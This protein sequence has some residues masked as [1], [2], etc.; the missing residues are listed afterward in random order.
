MR[1][2]AMRPRSPVLSPFV[3]SLHYHEADLP[4]EL[5]RVALE[6]VLPGA[7]TH[8]MI[9]LYENEFRTYHGADSTTVHRTHGAVLGGPHS[10]PTV[11]DTREQRWL[12]TVDF[13]LGGACAFFSSPLSEAR[14]QLI[15][16]DQLWGWD[17]R[18]LRERL[19]DELTPEAKLQ[20]LETVL[21]DHLVRSQV[22]D[23]A[24]PF[25][26]REFERGTSVSEVTDR[27]GLLPKTFVRR[28]RARVG[29]TPKRFSRIRRLQRVLG[30]VRNLAAADWSKVAAEHGY[31]DQAHLVHDFRALTG[32]TPAA[33][34]P[35]SPE[36]QNHVPIPR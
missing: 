29:L 10:H 9:N 33:Y 34:R 14:D 15:E 1:S 32:M 13:K 6:R 25:A 22:P 7:R 31:A 20:T 18:V 11:I 24:L 27:L 5:G 26:A 4:L 3:A 19:L 8:V 12:V 35:R 28:F 30:S 36:E 21:L 2:L 23:P 17:G 16:L